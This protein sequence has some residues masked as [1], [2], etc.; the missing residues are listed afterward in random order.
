MSALFSSPK[1]PPP[2][3]PAPPPPNGAAADAAAQSQAA[4]MAQAA[5]LRGRT[6]TL[7][8]SGGA[9]GLGS[10]GDTTSK[11]LLGQ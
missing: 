7:V 9:S 3:S 2:P 1:T 10:P 5:Q 4:M 6:S 11:Q 8:N